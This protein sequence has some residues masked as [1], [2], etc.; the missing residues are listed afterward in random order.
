MMPLRAFLTAPAFRRLRSRAGLAVGL[1]VLAVFIPVLCAVCYLAHQWFSASA[2]LERGEPRLARLLGLRDAADEVREAREIAEAA[3]SAAVYSGEMPADRIGTDLQQR[4]RGAADSAG[5]AISGSQVIEGKQEN[6][7][8][9]IMVAMSFEAS[10][11]QLQQ[12]LQI[13]AQQAPAVYVDNLVLMP[14]RARSGGGG[15]LIVQAR[16]CVLRQVS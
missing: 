7:F 6:G 4:L 16:F 15:R 13:L 2:A 10:H 14:M 1:S 3:L 12:L 8:E 9:Q 5:V 11:E